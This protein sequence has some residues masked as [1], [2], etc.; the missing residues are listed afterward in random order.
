[1]EQ[2][3]KEQVSIGM[4]FSKAY[5]IFKDNFQLLA[6]IYMVLGLAQLGSSLFQY[7]VGYE[8]QKVLAGGEI[9]YGMFKA[10][11][12]ASIVISIFVFAILCRVIVAYIKAV[13]KAYFGETL[14][15][16]MCMVESEKLGW[17]YF[18]ASFMYGIMA[19]PAIIPM[20]IYTLNDNLGVKLVMVP[21]ILG[22]MLFLHLN[23]SFGMNMTAYKP[24]ENN[25]FEYSKKLFKH[26]RMKY[27]G[28]NLLTL[29]ILLITLSPVIISTI[30]SDTRFTSLPMTFMEWLLGAIF[31]MFTTVLTVVCM[32][33]FDKAL[34][35]EDVIDDLVSEKFD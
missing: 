14:N 31:M 13:K 1:M 8:T 33:E 9:D 5:S 34:P 11:Q 21:F 2:D 28:I 29:L 30:V 23:Y 20:L 32:I 27:I 6:R 7:Y 22:W 15:Y 18:G 3:M 26:N 12:A 16:R 24:L 10:F 4:I 17:N 25:N 35:V 19:L